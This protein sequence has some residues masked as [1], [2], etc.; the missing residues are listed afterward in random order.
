MLETLIAQSV[1]LFLKRNELVQEQRGRLLLED[2]WSGVALPVHRQEPRD[3]V[4]RRCQLNSLLEFDLCRNLSRFFRLLQLG[5]S[6]LL[7]EV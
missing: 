4:Q 3:V 2:S 1:I 6:L 7:I 5:E